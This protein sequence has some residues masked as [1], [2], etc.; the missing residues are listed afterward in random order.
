M[1]AAPFPFYEPAEILGEQALNLQ[2]LAHHC[3]APAAWVIEHVHTGVLECDSEASSGDTHNWR[4]SS[5]TVVRARKIV[6]LER[7]FDADPQLAALA[8]DLIEEVQTLRRQ[9]QALQR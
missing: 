7:S 2:E 8:V 3:Q 5:H 1:T 4:F 9:L 6:Q